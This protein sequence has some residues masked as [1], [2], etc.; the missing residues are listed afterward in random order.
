[1]STPETIFPVIMVILIVSQIITVKEAIVG[2][3]NEGV[4]SV[5]ILFA[6]AKGF[7][8]ICVF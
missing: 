7:V 5:A 4:L 1:M 2:F 6:V 3:A 8:T